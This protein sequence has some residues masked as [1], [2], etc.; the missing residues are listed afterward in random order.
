MPKSVVLDV[1]CQK[2]TKHRFK[3]YCKKFPPYID[4]SG[5]GDFTF[6]NVYWD[7]GKNI[8]RLKVKYNLSKS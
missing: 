7:S 2:H 1:L 3:N 5:E 8:D 4:F 6:I